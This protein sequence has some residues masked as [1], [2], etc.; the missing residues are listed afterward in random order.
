M[1]SRAPSA[2]SRSEIASTGPNLDHVAPPAHRG[3]AHRGVRI[4]NQRSWPAPHWP[5][6]RRALGGPPQVRADYRRRAGVI[7]TADSRLRDLGSGVHVGTLT[8]DE[9]RARLAAIPPIQGRLAGTVDRLSARLRDVDARLAQLGPP[10]GASQ[11][12]EPEDTAAARENLAQTR[13]SRRR[14]AQTGT[15]AHGRRRPDQCSDRQS[16]SSEL[17]RRGLPIGGAQPVDPGPP[18]DDSVDNAIPIETARVGAILGGEGRAIAAAAR[19]WRGVLW[20]ALGS[21]VALFLAVPARLLLSR[22]GYRIVAAEDPTRLRRAALALWLALVA[23]LTPL[24][25]GLT[26]GAAL[27]AAERSTSDFDTLLGGVIQVVSGAALLEGLG[28]G[29]LSSGRPSWR[30]APLPEDLVVRLAPYPAVI[31]RAAGAAALVRERSTR[32]LAA[33]WRPRSSGSGSRSSLRSWRSARRCG[34][35]PAGA[36]RS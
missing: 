33:R 31:A 13:R 3:Y 14:P 23:G 27:A 12:P 35:R 24:F 29:L 15:P 2:L 8:D 19:G 5:K 1:A 7:T 30:L 26:I 17:Q 25:A 16:T 18:P 11:P 10:P 28:R 36:P 20:I 4:L 32:R 34:R 22:P 6:R 9:L 21:V